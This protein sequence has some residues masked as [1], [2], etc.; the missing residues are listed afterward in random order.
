MTSLPTGPGRAAVT[1]SLEPSGLMTA[2]PV[3]QGC[4]ARASPGGS[5]DLWCSPPVN[6]VS[7]A[8][9]HVAADSS[10]PAAFPPPFTVVMQVVQGQRLRTQTAPVTGPGNR[11]GESG[12]NRRT[13]DAR[14]S[15]IGDISP[16]SPQSCSSALLGPVGSLAP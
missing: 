14:F 15:T 7:A 9:A 4:P 11:F 12:M 8:S 3:L 16:D 13:A 1:T 2:Y 6:G 5:G 10:E